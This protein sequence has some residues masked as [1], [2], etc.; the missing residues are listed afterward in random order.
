MSN[1]LSAWVEI[2]KELGAPLWEVFRA[3]MCEGTNAIHVHETFSD[4]SGEHGRPAMM[5]VIGP[6][7][8]ASVMRLETTWSRDAEPYRA[9][10]TTRYW[11]PAQEVDDE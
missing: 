4:P 2:P 10:A 7:G 1:K 9:D 11:L 6:S 8:G 3:H 5:T